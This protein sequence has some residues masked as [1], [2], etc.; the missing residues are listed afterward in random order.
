MK[1]IKCGG[2]VVLKERRAAI[3]VRDTDREGCV[4]WNKG[5]LWIEDDEADRKYW[6][7]C[8]QCGEVYKYDAAA[9]KLVY[10]PENRT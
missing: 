3:L 6:G 7:E 9:D 4:D 5:I 8:L 2:D 10:V 1:C